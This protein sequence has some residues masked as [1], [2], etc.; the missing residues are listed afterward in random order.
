MQGSIDQVH[1]A[2][3]AGQNSTGIRAR[4]DLLRVEAVKEK[5]GRSCRVSR[6]RKLNGQID[7]STG[8]HSPLAL[9]LSSLQFFSVL[10]NCS[11]F[12]TV[13]YIGSHTNIV[14]QPFRWQNEHPTRILSFLFTSLVHF[15][16]R[17]I[18]A[19]FVFF[20]LN[21]NYSLLSVCIICVCV[22]I[23]LWDFELTIF[24]CLFVNPCCVRLAGRV[25]SEGRVLFPLVWTIWTDS[26]WPI[27]WRKKKKKSTDVGRH[28]QRKL[29]IS[30][31]PSFI[32]FLWT[33]LYLEAA[34]ARATAR[35]TATASAGRRWIWRQRAKWSVRQ[36][37]N[38]LQCASLPCA[39][40]LELVESLGAGRAL[41][42]SK[43]SIHP[44]RLPSM[45]P[46][47][48]SPVSILFYFSPWSVIF[49]DNS[50]IQRKKKSYKIT[51]KKNILLVEMETK[52]RE[53][54]KNTTPT[55]LLLPNLVLCVVYVCVCVC[56]FPLLSIS[57]FLWVV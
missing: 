21:N 5:A 26:K 1:L 53:Y 28:H 2:R 52:K 14:K 7:S 41:R 13:R 32:I 50:I 3:T 34:T 24:H 4:Q 15:L 37:I 22:V 54:S 57:G 16:C 48:F 38:P 23:L 30:F 31:G 45:A 12:V 49:F 39:F 56:R 55:L 10:C 18:S 6:Q 8:F 43:R 46:A 19:V 25:V 11:P 40:P 47:I 35:T 27:R 9:E 33:I 44:N 51:G 20:F 42:D 36:Q 17:I 29:W